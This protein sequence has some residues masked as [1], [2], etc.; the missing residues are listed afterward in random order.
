LQQKFV[1]AGL[2]EQTGDWP[3]AL[4]LYQNLGNVGAEYANEVKLGIARC[5]ARGRTQ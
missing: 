4:E 2:R 5:K 1:L 3:G